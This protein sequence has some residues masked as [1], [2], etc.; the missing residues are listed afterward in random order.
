MGREL[1]RLVDIQKIYVMDR[2]EVPAL[3]GITLSIAKGEF[4]S[5]MGPSSSGKS[6]LMNLIGCLDRPTRG[7]VFID[8]KDVS[9]LNDNSLAEIRREKI[10]FVFQQFNLIPRLTALENVTL[11][12]WFAGTEKN[13]RVKRA[14]TLLERV[15]LQER[16]R[17]K[18][19]ELSGGERQRVS[20]ARALAND[21]ELIL[22]DEPTGNLDSKTGNEI[23]ELLESLN[24]DGKTI[25]M[26]THDPDYGRRAQR[27][28]KLKDGLIEG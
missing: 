21:P 16:I 12:M 26:V 13:R 23:L 8:G 27:M 1:I 6:T 24:N 19:T 11:P 5:M 4:V 10:G 3:R 17:H 25:I 28:I 14:T 2:V 15:G 20:I 7:K 22:A 18:P 9:K